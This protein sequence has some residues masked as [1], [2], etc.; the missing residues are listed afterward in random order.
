MGKLFAGIGLCLLVAS[1]IYGQ[2]AY[3]NPVGHVND[4]ADVM[5]FATEQGLESKLREYRDKTSIEIAVAIVDSLGGVTV[6]EYA[7]NLFNKW[8]VGDSVKNNGILV[9]VAPNEREMKI[10]V[11]YGMEPDLTDLQA[12]R[13]INYVII[14]YFK[15]GKMA[16][17]VVAGVDAILNDLGSTPFETRL[18]ERRIA[19]EERQVEQIKQAEDTKIF[20]V[21]FGLGLLAL[22]V[23]GVPA[24]LIY[25]AINRK[26]KLKEI[27]QKN[28]ELLSECQVLIKK[29]KQN[30]PT[31]RNNLEDLKK[32]TPGSVWGSWAK[33]VSNAPNSIRAFDARVDELIKESHENG[34]EKSEQTFT[35]ISSFQTTILG[36]VGLSESIKSMVN[37]FRQARDKSP[38]LLK[39]VLA[40]IESSKVA[41]THKDVSDRARQYLTEATEKCA[42]ASY[43]MKEQV[44]NW[45]SVLWAIE[46]AAVLV[47]KAKSVADS[48]KASAEE[49]R[50]PKPTY[51]PTH[52]PTYKSSRSSGG[53][54]RGG[55]GGFGGGRSG[56]GGARGKW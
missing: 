41:L 9:L 43:L 5:D 44:V 22:V 38:E 21:F 12:G 31:A 1:T 18:E 51:R 25:K 39:S 27:F 11:G 2:V 6:D 14:P 13:V 45:L 53:G 37:K 47:A 28:N 46:I 50:R 40:D 23:I 19:E 55:F 35:D 4:F 34:W 16:E 33:F 42:L 32:E 26:K 8:G 3:P 15:D 48:D 29:A 7:L 54:S 49:S 20:M 52:S 17:G 24:G 10:E 36:V 56:G 30:Y